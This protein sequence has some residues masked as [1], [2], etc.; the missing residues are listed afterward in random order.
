MA[1][2]EPT[3]ACGG[4][5]LWMHEAAPLGG[6]QRSLEAGLRELRAPM[7]VS[8]EEEE[9][10]EEERRRSLAEKRRWR[11]KVKVKVKRGI[12]MEVGGSFCEIPEF[13]SVCEEERVKNGVFIYASEL[14]REREIR[15]AV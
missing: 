1:S 3:A 2:G 5:E 10:E 11:E 15:W 12:A 14:E 6:E 7:L 4:A 8:M 9:E 13:F